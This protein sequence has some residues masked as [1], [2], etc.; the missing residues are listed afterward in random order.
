MIEKMGEEFPMLIGQTGPLENQRWAINSN[1]TLGRDPE[2]DIVIPDRQ[3]SR[4]HAR[5]TPSQEGITIEDLGSKNGTYWNQKLIDEPHLLQDGDIVQVA[6]AQAFAF[7]SSDATLPLD[8][9]KLAITLTAETADR[10]S[11]VL[12]LDQRSRRVWI[13]DQEIQPTLSRPQ[14]ILLNLL[15]ENE[16]RLVTRQDIISAVWKDQ[17]ADG[18]SEQALDALV[19]RLRDRIA[20]IDK[21]HQYILTVRGHGLRLNIHPDTQSTSVD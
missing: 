5:L 1:V 12:R 3:V 16:G 2:C 15:Y 8:L 4:F 11:N 10:H 17:E 6:L 21:K 18:V 7:I 13:R 14:F 9:S 20:S 19:R